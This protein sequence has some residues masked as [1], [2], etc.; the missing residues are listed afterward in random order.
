M[1]IEQFKQLVNG[2]IDERLGELVGNTHDLME[3][4]LYEILEGQAAYHMTNKLASEFE[5]MFDKAFVGIIK[6]EYARIMSEGWEDDVVTAELDGEVMT[7]VQPP[8]ATCF[9]EGA[10]TEQHTYEPGCLLF[11]QPAPEPV[12]PRKKLASV[13]VESQQASEKQGE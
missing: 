3:K 12:V 5:K 8:E 10:C 7:P 4:R 1:D 9:P 2:I 6:S 13:P 11:P